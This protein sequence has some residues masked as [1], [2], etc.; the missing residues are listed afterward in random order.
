V[1]P[2]GARAKLRGGRSAARGRTISSARGVR[3]APAGGSFAGVRRIPLD[4]VLLPALAAIG[5]VE[6]LTDDTLTSKG[7]ATGVVASLLVV[8]VLAFRRRAPE[9]TFLAVFALVSAW[10]TIGYGWRQGPLA[11]FLDLMLATFALGLHARGRRA[12]YVLVGALAVG[13]VRDGYGLAR[14]L[15]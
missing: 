6:A 1:L 11:G 8:A 13:I 14:G 4:A 9:A 7:Q 5:V 12:L 2:S 15:E 3:S 10:M